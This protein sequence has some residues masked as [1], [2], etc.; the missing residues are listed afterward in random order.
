MLLCCI[1]DTQNCGAKV[2]FYFCRK[3]FHRIGLGPQYRIA[4]WENIFYSY[5]RSKCHVN[6]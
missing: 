5:Y 6:T 4:S 3:W 2:V 1:T